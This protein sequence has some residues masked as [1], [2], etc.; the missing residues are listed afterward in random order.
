MCYQHEPKAFLT[1][2]L[3]CPT[4][5]Y[6]N[7]LAELAYSYFVSVRVL[8]VASCQGLLNLILNYKLSVMNYATSAVLIGPGYQEIA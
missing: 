7:S 4:I 1:C 8:I 2:D 6:V 3:A 5:V